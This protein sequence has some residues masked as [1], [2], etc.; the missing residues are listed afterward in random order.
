MIRQYLLC[1][2]PQARSHDPDSERQPLLD[3]DVLP[4]SADPPRAPP[5]RT[6][7]EHEAEQALRRR[8]LDLAS[9]RLVNILSPHPFTHA[10]PRPSS[11]PPPPPPAPDSLASSPTLTSSPPPHAHAAGKRRQTTRAPSS[12]ASSTAW[13]PAPDAPIAPVRVVHLGQNWEVVHDDDGAD[14]APSA[15]DPLVTPSTM[16]RQRRHPHGKDSAA[17]RPPSS[18]SMRTLPRG[19]GGGASQPS[20]LRGHSQAYSDGEARLGDDDDENDEDGEDDGDGESE[21]RFGTVNSYRTAASS[22]GSRFAIGLRDIWGT[23]DPDPD[24]LDPASQRDLE[25]AVAELERSID[26]WTLQPVA[27]IVADLASY[28]PAAATTSATK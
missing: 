22:G 27:P 19:G 25:R 26:D 15:R 11:P 6:T 12:S 13:R 28:K 1:C 5:T 10:P 17:T 16:R 18:H 3:P 23:G 21:S 2:L 9:E 14:T 24:E 7:E 4:Q 20:P 8:I